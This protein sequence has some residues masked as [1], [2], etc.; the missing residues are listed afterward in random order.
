MLRSRSGLWRGRGSGSS[1]VDARAHGQ[2]AG[3]ASGRRSRHRRAA[4]RAGEAGGGGVRARAMPARREARGA[5]AVSPA[6][7]AAVANEAPRMP[8]DSCTFLETKSRRDGAPA[9]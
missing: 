5:A 6:L 9:G 2:R 3:Q 7:D 4:A 1:V 8:K